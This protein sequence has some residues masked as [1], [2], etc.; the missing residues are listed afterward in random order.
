MSYFS[1]LGK[2][3]LHDA[4]NICSHPECTEA[5]IYPAPSAGNISDYNFLCL[6]HV[7][8]YNQNWNFF[9]HMNADEAHAFR[10]YARAGERTTHK[11]IP[12]TQQYR[13]S[14]A[15][16]YPKTDIACDTPLYPEATIHLDTLNLHYSSDI[17]TIRQRYRSLV[18]R[19]HPDIA[20]ATGT[21][22]LKDIIYAYKE[23]KKIYGFR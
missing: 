9:T 18:K 1:D 20:G 21:E 8:E 10:K 22:E 19:L 11:R 4:V 5:G 16:E 2:E 6:H 23:L 7:R 17:E 14:T 12:P 3:T 15:T 13:H